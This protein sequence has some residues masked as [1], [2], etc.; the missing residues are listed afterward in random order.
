MKAYSA[1]HFMRQ[2]NLDKKIRDGIRKKNSKAVGFMNIDSKYVNKILANQVQ[3]SIK[4]SS[5]QFRYIK[6]S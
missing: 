6:V 4:I 2:T 3:F 5:V 1:T